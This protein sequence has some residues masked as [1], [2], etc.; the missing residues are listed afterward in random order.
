MVR[1]RRRVDE[2]GGFEGADRS[3]NRRSEWLTEMK[4][5]M[6]DQTDRSIHR[7]KPSSAD[8]APPAPTVSITRTDSGQSITPVS[9]PHRLDPPLSGTSLLLST[10]EPITTLS[11]YLNSHQTSALLHFSCTPVLQPTVEMDAQPESRASNRS[12]PH[13]SPENAM[14]SWPTDS[15]A[16]TK[17]ILYRDLSWTSSSVQGLL[18]YVKISEI[19]FTNGARLFA[20]QLPSNDTNWTGLLNS[21]NAPR[22]VK[23][24][25][26]MDDPRAEW[27]RLASRMRPV[28]LPWSHGHPCGIA[29]AHLANNPYRWRGV[30]IQAFGNRNINPCQCCEA[31]FADN[32]HAVPSPQD[33]TVN[34]GRVLSPF[35]QCISV[36][37]PDNKTS[38]LSTTCGNCKFMV[39]LS[40][41]WSDL[42]DHSLTPFSL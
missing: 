41:Q 42:S 22:A 6:A 31:R 17:P 4:E 14:Q 32:W 40:P 36:R 37:L 9:R 21:A 33:N 38:D 16:D 13:V 35:T 7:D 23:N 20:W 19:P 5:R 12:R 29:L 25:F 8:R 24:Y 1:E 26:I 30:F 15:Q 3:R 11:A 28:I 18:K 27:R 34:R 2:R 39:Y 10:A